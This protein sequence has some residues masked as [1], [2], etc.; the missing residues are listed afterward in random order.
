MKSTA[1]KKQRL[2]FF[3]INCTAFAILFSL[4]SFI[5][6]K[7]IQHSAYT[8][9]D[10]TL[11][12]M[13]NDPSLLDKEIRI[14][15]KDENGGHIGMPK[16]NFEGPNNQFN[17]VVILWGDDGKI[18]NQATVEDRL[19]NLEEPTFDKKKYPFSFHHLFK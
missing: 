18:L 9:T 19:E 6:I 7:V 17:T 15:N 16:F 1:S 4:L 12:R 14:L 13:A 11:E 3:L 2:K 10:S 5:T 8:E